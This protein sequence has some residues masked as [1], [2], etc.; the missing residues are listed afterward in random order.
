MTKQ[1]QLIEE[2]N[3][4]LKSGKPSIINDWYN[5]FE[6]ITDDMLK[7]IR[8]HRVLWNQ[9]QNFGPYKAG[10][11]MDQPDDSNHIRIIMATQDVIEQIYN[12]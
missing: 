1:E 3:A 7:F 2:A 6:D 4:L 12:L 11:V 9:Q 8:E 5:T 10:L